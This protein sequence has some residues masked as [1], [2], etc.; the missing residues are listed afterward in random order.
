VTHNDP[1]AASTV[2]GKVSTGYGRLDE[3]LQGGFF[4]GSAI[5][6][7]SPASSEVPILV[8]SFLKAS[9]E[10]S[11]LICRSQSSAEAVLRPDDSNLK[12]MICSEKPI[13]PSKNMLPGKGI[14]NLT[15]LNFQITE[16]ISSVQPKRVV[17]E[18]LSDILLR[19]KALQT[20]KWLSELLEKLRSRDITTLAVL[21]PYMH[22]AEEVQAL[23]DLFDGN[24]EM[25]E[26]DVGGQLQKFLRIKWIHRV[27]AAGKELP[28]LDLTAEGFGNIQQPVVVVTPIK[29]PR[30]LTP[31]VGRAVEISR[32]KTAFEKSLANRSSVVALQGEAG[33]GKTRLMQELAV[34]AQSKRSTALTGNASEG[35][36]PYSPWIE[37]ARQYIGQAP[38]EL[39]RRIL[40]PYVSE[41]AR[42]VPDIA[43]KVGTIPPSKPLGEQQD[44]IRLFE[45]VTQF[46]ISISSESPL[47]LL[48][49]DMHSADQSSLELL[50]Y[51]VRST[52]NLRVLTA[53][54]Y[55]SE[56]VQ[57]SSP[58]YQTLMKFNRQRLLETIQV[59]NLNKEETTELIK[60]M[61][62]EQAVSP[63]FGDL[64]YQ[65]T[66]GNPFFVEE[67]LRSLVEDGI[68]FRTEKKWDRKPIQEIVLPESVRSVLKSRLTKLQPE[69]MNLL[70]MA[71]VIGPEFDFEVLREVTKTQEDTLLERL[72]ESITA[73][74]ISEVPN[75]KD[76]FRF[77]DN[78]IRE[79][80]LGDLIRSRQM[81]YHVRIAEA[82]EKAYSKNLQNQAETIATH[83][84][85]GSDT[86][87][88]IKYSLM[89][90][91]R[92]RAIHAYDQAIKNYKRAV[93]LIDLEKNKEKE[94]EPLLRKLAECYFFAGQFENAI[95]AYQEALA[96]LEQSSDKKGCARVCLAL[97]RTYIRAE[98][99][100]AQGFTEATQTLTRGL[101][102][103]RDE[104]ESFEEAS[105]YGLLAQLHGIMDKWDEAL[106]W[107][108][109]AR[110]AG[111]KTGNYFAASEALA[112]KGSFLTDTGKIDEGLP[113][114]QQALEMAVKH[115][116][117]DLT[118]YFLSNL[119]VY[120]YPRS[121]AKAREFAVRHCEYRKHANDIM[122][123]AGA[124]ASLSHVDF[125]MGDWAKA[126]EEEK[127]AVEIVEKLG[128]A[129]NME[130][131][132]S[133]EGWTWLM[134]G[135]LQKAEAHFQNASRLLKE[136]SKITDT[137]GVH[138]GLALLMLEQGREDEAKAHLERCVNAFRK[139]EYTTEPISHIE[140]LLHLTSI[141][142]KRKEIEKAR[143]FSQW[144]KRLAETLKSDAGLALACQA[145]ASLLLASD[146][147]KGAEEAYLKALDFWGKAGWPYYHAKALVAYSEA[148]A[149][150]NPDESKKRLQQAAE[151]FSKLGAKWELEKAE[152]KL[153]AQA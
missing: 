140:T 57:S 18:I 11:L 86:E 29:E 103:L 92:N 41:F 147:R 114:W 64:V 47:V 105:I 32:L 42:L 26:R 79:L 133:V 90:G 30:W 130:A 31:L 65:R 95:G 129:S 97:A 134:M 50:E 138:L 141:S 13:P 94:K 58:L 137:V 121:L 44:K 35:G 55:R 122:G 7:S 45:A 60:Q 149:P 127:A 126:L 71:S 143:E 17:L 20:R 142:A 19:H 22:A 4:A 33:V 67:V 27:E 38:G 53:C 109:K 10:A 72:E 68:V 152:A 49:D 89:A 128:L 24:L 43:V 54:S 70:T 5:L 146:D 9:K 76:V 73:G 131:A 78:R 34:Y 62:G 135:D 151:I 16:T 23:V 51:F 118:C 104:P 139:W 6:L 113:L 93:D 117:Y 132:Q 107:A 40:G 2:R 48:L 87:R 69:T 14:D 21:N 61:F 111:N 39:L 124:L 101:D 123:E 108:E 56:D 46:F 25:V 102:Y 116:E 150:T 59:K 52:S 119:E 115:D 110:E 1:S 136:G 120:T 15:E 91:D 81:R 96:I 37:I 3:A 145:E 85:E 88:T 112:M 77:A 144:A 82:M 153:S 75:R 98:T 84:S 125:L 12:C 36:L 106:T 148:I 28:L 74:L 100:A 83:F 8:S 80:L 63:E 66:G 99:D